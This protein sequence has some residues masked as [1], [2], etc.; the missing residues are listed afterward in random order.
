MQHNGDLACNKQDAPCHRPVRQGEGEEAQTAGGGG[1]AGDFRESILDLWGTAGNSHLVQLP[2]T[3][4]DGRGR[5]LSSGGGQPKKFLKELDADDKG[6]G[7]VGGRPEIIRFFK[8][9]CPGG[10]NFWVRDVGPNPLYGAGPR[11]LP[12]QSRVT[13]HWGVSSW[14]RGGGMG[15]SSAGGSDGGSGF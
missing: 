6:T 10:V 12:E 7:Q 14:S 8:D 1:A 11:Q 13:D 15:L 9:M 3:G 4:Y 5:R 2:G